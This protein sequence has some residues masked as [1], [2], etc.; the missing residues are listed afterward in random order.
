MVKVYRRYTATEMFQSVS[1]N[2]CK[3]EETCKEKLNWSTNVER[4]QSSH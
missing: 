3:V 2:D 4:S 1:K